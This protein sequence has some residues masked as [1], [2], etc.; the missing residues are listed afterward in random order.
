[1]A[2]ADEPRLPLGKLLAELREREEC[3]AEGEVFAVDGPRAHA[4]DDAENSARAGRY[5]APREWR[6]EPDVGRV[7]HG[8]RNRVDRLQ[9]LGNAVVPQIPALI[10][11]AIIEAETKRHDDIEERNA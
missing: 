11:Q 6:L 2:H 3:A 10:G 1:V 8:V 4:A 5:I 9:A 7:A